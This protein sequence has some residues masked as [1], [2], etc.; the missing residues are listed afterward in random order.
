[1]GSRD[2]DRTPELHLGD[3]DAVGIESLSLTVLPFAAGARI[4][5]GLR[6]EVSGAHASARLVRADGASTT[7]SGLT[8]SSIRATMPFGRDLVTLTGVAI[9]PTGD[10]SHSL[11]EAQVAGLI[12]SD[13]LPFRVTHW[14]SGGGAA[15]NVAVARRVGQL[16]L[17]ASVGYRIAAEF[18]PLQTEAFAYRP[19]DEL[20][21]R[22]AVD[23]SRSDDAKSSAQ[24]TLYRYGND[25]LDGRNL[26]QPG[27]RIEV[28]SSTTFPAGADATGV[29]YSAMVHRLQG[30]APEGVADSSPLPLPEPPEQTLLLLGTGFRVPW[31]GAVLLPLAEVRAFRQADGVG[32]GVV[33]SAGTSAELRLRGLSTALDGLVRKSCC[34]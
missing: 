10:Q 5:R 22:V 25:R 20:R 1:M 21:V 4:G 29:T 32:Q 33:G 28:V 23:R 3:P 2:G 26:F 12:A 13:L 34:S 24:V 6:I 27:D 18:E 8:D 16:G 30:A 9:L 15:A 31:L 7:V 11:E 14:G 17:G 19:G